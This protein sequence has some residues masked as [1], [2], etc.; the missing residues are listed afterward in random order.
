[1]EWI[2]LDITEL[3]K[4]DFSQI[5][6]DSTHTL[7]LSVDETKTFINWEGKEQPSFLSELETLEGPYTK[8]QIWAILQTDYWKIETSI[9][10]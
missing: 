9:P 2:I 7:R 8:D 1:M 5:N 6:E 4:I 3:N 10:V